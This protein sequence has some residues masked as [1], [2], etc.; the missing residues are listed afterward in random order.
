MLKEHLT[1]H[2]I[3]C[4]QGFKNFCFFGLE[5]E[6][7]IDD[8]F[9]PPLNFSIHFSDNFAI[10][11][12]NFPPIIFDFRFS[13]FDANFRF[14]FFVNVDIEDF[15]LAHYKRLRFEK[16]SDLKDHITL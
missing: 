13:G 15:A 12:F 8:E 16:P 2:F 3:Q 1:N 14:A 4:I 5:F 10:Q 9:L 11:W 6:L 7:E